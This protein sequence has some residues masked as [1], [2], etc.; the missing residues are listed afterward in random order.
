MTKN[1]KHENGIIFDVWEEVS[2][3]TIKNCFRKCGFDQNSY[4]NDD[5]KVLDDEFKALFDELADSSMTAE[6]YIDFD[7]ET[8]S[9]APAVNADEVDWRV[10]SVKNCVKEYLQEESGIDET[11]ESDREES[12]D[13]VEEVEPEEISPRDALIIIDKLMNL[14]ELNSNERS[15]LSSIKD[16]LETVRINNKKQKTIKQFYH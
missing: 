11:H 10:S 6:E 15:S 8:C 16:K 7:I 9:S 1:Q 5:E 4:G 12:D 14:K 13:E 3:D 2:T